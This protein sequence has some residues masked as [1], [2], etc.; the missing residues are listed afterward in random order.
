MDKK[1]ENFQVSSNG[2]LAVF[3][4][5]LVSENG[6][7]LSYAQG[8]YSEY[9][10]FIWLAKISRSRVVPSEIVDKVWH[11]HITFTQ[12]YWH[13]LCRDTLG[14]EFHHLPS[15]NTKECQRL[16]YQHYKNT[17]KMYENEFGEKPD[18]RY[19]PVRE[20]N[21]LDIS[22]YFIL[23]LFTLTF[24]TACSLSSDGT[25]VTALK[26]IIGIYVVYKV[27]KWLFENRGGGGGNGHGCSG[28]CGSS[29]G[30]D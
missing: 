19:W 6:W 12:S 2:D 11:L 30:G 5:K 22:K 17:L 26:W 20:T 16:D 7:T 21:K 15:S 24:L 4:H 28:S 14:F 27:I 18:G 1:I 13:D 10:K 9:K 3:W 23:S 29:C 8:A 25:V